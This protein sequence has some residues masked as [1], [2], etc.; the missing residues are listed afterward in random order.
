MESE[1]LL[2]DIQ[3]DVITPQEDATSNPF[4]EPSEAS[5]QN[6]GSQLNNG[7][8][9]DQK[10]TLQMVAE[11]ADG[12]TEVIVTKTAKVLEPVTNFVSPILRNF[13]EKVVDATGSINKSVCDMV[14]IHQ[15]SP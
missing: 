5:P 2:S 10:S 11:K 14:G 1:P 7:A 4:Y 3:N 12:V 6:D 9:N 8:Q 15:N 13:F